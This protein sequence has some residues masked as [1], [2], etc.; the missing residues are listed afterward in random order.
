MGFLLRFT[1]SVVQLFY[2][3][4]IFFKFSVSLGKLSFELQTSCAHLVRVRIVVT[5]CLVSRIVLDVAVCR[6]M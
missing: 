2:S 6:C 3:K 4:Y 5:F 1:K